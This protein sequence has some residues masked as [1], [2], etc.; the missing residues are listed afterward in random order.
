LAR[1]RQVEDGFTERK[2]TAQRTDV[3]EALVAFANSVPPEREAVLYLG[4]RDNG[5]V[6]GVVNPDK[7]Q[8]DV[9][10]WAQQ[11]CPAIT[12]QCEAIL[13]DDQHTVVAVIVP[14][15]AQRPHFAGQAYK[16]VGSKTVKASPEMLDEL[17]ASRNTKAGA[18]LR[19]KDAHPTDAVT[20]T[21][22]YFD[23]IREEPFLLERECRIEGCSAHSVELL[24][25]SAGRSHSVPLEFVILSADPVNHRSLRLRV[26]ELGW[27][28]V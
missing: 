16:R 14:A 11:C 3:I 9:H 6:V 5:E 22:P 27:M 26:T 15:S 19:F 2:L 10:D 12:V 28:I 7:V 1:L 20:V 4:V 18:I 25:I 23:P 13:L 8:R 24:E 21:I 17:I